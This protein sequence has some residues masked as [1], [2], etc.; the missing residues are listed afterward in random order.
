MINGLRMLVCQGSWF[1]FAGRRKG[2]V[3]ISREEFPGIIDVP[4][5]KDQ[6]VTGRRSAKAIA[7]RGGQPGVGNEAP[8]EPFGCDRVKTNLR[9][10]A[11][12]KGGF[13]RGVLLASF[14]TGT[15]YL[16]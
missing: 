3:W 8:T 15:T 16:F 12:I 13:R 7:G 10:S 14:F 11:G 4:G 2:P 1:S 6:D 5:E 9:L